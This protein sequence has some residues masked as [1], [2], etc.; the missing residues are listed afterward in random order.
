MAGCAL[1]AMC[2][3]TD[4]GDIGLLGGGAAIDAG[5]YGFPALGVLLVFVVCAF[6]VASGGVPPLFVFPDRPTWTSVH[7]DFRSVFCA[8]ST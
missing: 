5:L 6:S 3:V 2:Q 7:D 4:R 8:C 1:T